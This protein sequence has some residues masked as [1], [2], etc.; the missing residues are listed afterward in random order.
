MDTAAGKPPN[1]LIAALKTA[2][3]T[4]GHKR[5]EI[6]FRIGRLVNSK[7]VP[8]VTRDAF[9]KIQDHLK[10]L[11]STEINTTETIFRDC[12][13]I[14]DHDSQTTSVLHKK[15]IHNTDV[16]SAMPPWTVRAS[17]ALEE[18]G[19]LEDLGPASSVYERN[20]RR[21]RFTSK[22]WAIDLTRVASNLPDD[23]DSDSETYE[24]EI[25]LLDVDSLYTRTVME[26]LHWGLKIS[27][28][29]VGFASADAS[30]DASAGA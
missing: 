4:Y 22:G 5:L 12:K 16:E 2:I 28:D 3:A 24:V 9:A 25:E 7:F 11:P 1:A 10:S 19:A 13:R 8:G 26:V 30:A 18:P 15:K 23:L 21:T 14:Y 29:M 6:E 17:L 27:N 20:K